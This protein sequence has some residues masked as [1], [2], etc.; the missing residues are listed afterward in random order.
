L[1]LLIE[2]SFCDQLK[3]IQAIAL[4]PCKP[5][6]LSRFKVGDQCLIKFVFYFG[7]GKSK[8]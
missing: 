7:L 8:E 5:I 3:A 6:D 4:N 2:S 1:L